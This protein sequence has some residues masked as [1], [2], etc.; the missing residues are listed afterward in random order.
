MKLALLLAAGI[1][2]A[3]PARPTPPRRHG[4]HRPSLPAHLR[5][6]PSVTNCTEWFFTQRI[7][8]L[9]SV[10]PPLGNTT[11]EQRVYTYD[12]HYQPGGP[13]FFYTGN[14]ADV[15]LYVN[16]TGLMWENA[17]RFGAMLV[18]AEHRYFG[19]SQPF[20]SLE[21]SFQHEQY[22]TVE[23][24]L[25]DFAALAKHLRSSLDPQVQDATAIVSFGGSY[26][27]MLSSW[28]R[29]KYPHV[30][31]GA[32]AA[33]API[34]S[35]EGEDPACDPNFYAQGVS[36]DV[37]TDGG[38]S[39]G[40][41]EA[42]F[43][44]AFAKERLAYIGETAEGRAALEDAFQLCEPLP[45]DPSSGWTVTY[46]IN[47]AL[48]YMAMG[49]YP[50]PSSYILNGDGILPAFP[51]ITGCDDFLSTDLVAVDEGCADDLTNP[52]PALLEG[53]ASFAGIYYNYSGTLTCNNLTAPV[54]EESEIVNALWN[55]L[56]CTEI[57][58]LFGQDGV[59][60]IFW[61]APWNATESAEY[62][63][64]SEGVWPRED[65]LTLSLGDHEDWT[66]GTSNIVWS[67]GELDPWRGGG[68]QVNLSAS[69]HS[70]VI[71]KAAHHLDLMFSTDQDT[72]AVID[73]RAFEMDN[74]QQ[75][76]DERAAA[77][78]AR[79]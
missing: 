78:A 45:D 33:S 13:I 74:V 76:I 73:A 70:V 66:R 55:Y 54:N 22:L 62:C 4:R 17:E 49:N 60:D 58:Q 56:Y 41:C 35:F 77:A 43:R 42:N 50:Y 19:E 12:E 75:W 5:G 9:T 65:W 36:F 18:W 38:V 69:L 51:V 29:F 23:Q 53:M 59:N 67:Q 15:Q 57:F 71:N 6:T 26:G 64:A 10:V 47:E 14:E 34:W 31:D 48:S 3:A 16:A 20:G 28:F 39:N 8:H 61:P 7:D 63:F 40:W 37:T 44:E 30:V 2:S 46:W 24:A 68:P 1:V 72:Q 25:A 27:G 52:C 21:V 32:I 11:F 79:R